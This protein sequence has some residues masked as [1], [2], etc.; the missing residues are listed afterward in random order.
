MTTENLKNPPIQP[1]NDELT[2][3]QLDKVAGGTAKSTTTQEEFVRIQMTDV[4]I[5]SH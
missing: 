2:D 3:D 5:S 4:I 1:A